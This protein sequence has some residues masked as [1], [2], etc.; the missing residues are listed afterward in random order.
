MQKARIR[1]LIVNI[2]L[3]VL[4]SIIFFKTSLVNER[5]VNYISYKFMISTFVC[6]WVIPISFIWMGI[7]KR[8]IDNISKIFS[9]TFR[10]MVLLNTVIIVCGSES[11]KHRIIV[12]ICVILACLLIVGIHMYMETRPRCGLVTKL[13]RE[14]IEKAL[15]ILQMCHSLLN[16]EKQEQLLVLMNDLVLCIQGEMCIVHGIDTNIFQECLE[17]Q[18]GILANDENKTNLHIEIVR[19]LIHLAE[20]FEEQKM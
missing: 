1:E 16:E 14:R 12:N 6:F 13:E 10:A 2:S 17:I 3:I 20:Q 11:M 18:N 15:S 8:L 9:T 19:Q 7:K 4:I 5:E